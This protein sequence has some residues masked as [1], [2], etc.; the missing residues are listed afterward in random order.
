[1]PDASRCRPHPNRSAGVARRSWATVF[2]ALLRAKPGPRA[3]GDTPT[4]GSP[5][6][7]LARRLDGVGED[8][9]LIPQPL[10][11]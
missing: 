2:V 9:I 4:R 1:M 8:I 5:F 6:V 10:F 3:A 11:L 7:G